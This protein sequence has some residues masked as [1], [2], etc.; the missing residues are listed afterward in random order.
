MKWLKQLARLF[1]R[2]R[3]LDD[4][5]CRRKECDQVG[6]WRPVLELADVAGQKWTH[7]L[8]VYVCEEHKKEMTDRGDATMW[9]MTLQLWEFLESEAK[10]DGISPFRES[11]TT[12]WI[13]VLN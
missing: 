8:N 2:R 6:R 11:T 13:K 9:F 12:K 7:E 4:P 5:Q 1:G 10:K 3:D